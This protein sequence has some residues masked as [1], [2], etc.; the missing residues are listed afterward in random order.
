MN[1]FQ[2]TNL[3]DDVAYQFACELMDMDN[4][5]DYMVFETII[6]NWDWPFNNMRCW[7]E[8]NGKWRWMF[9]DGDAALISSQIDIFSNAAVYLPPESWSNYPYATLVFGKLLENEQF[10]MAFESRAME[11]FEGMFKY[12]S[13]YPLF[14]G[15]ID[16]LR[17][18]VGE[19]VY[20]FG[21]PVSIDA[22]EQAHAYTDGFLFHRFE[23]FWENWYEFLELFEHAV[24][25]MCVYPNPSTDEMHLNFV[26]DASYT[27]EIAIYDMM[28]R[29]VFAQSCSFDKGANEII[30]HPDL[31]AGIYVLKIGEKA[32]KIARQ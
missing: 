22:W 4:F 18:N 3:A 19:H 9:F 2:N 32:I 21:N 26:A 27:T 17:P 23:T 25:T 12:D 5:I 7:Q 6:A 16:T 8:G 10:K 13:I 31:A 29:R 14:Q 28:G 11:L 20:R 1:W 15:I 24:E 30:L